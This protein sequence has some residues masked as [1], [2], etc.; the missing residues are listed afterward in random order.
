MAHLH[1][2]SGQVAAP[3][4]TLSGGCCARLPTIEGWP[5]TA[6]AR[7]TTTMLASCIPDDARVALI[8]HDSPTDN[9]GR[10]GQRPDAKQQGKEKAEA[11]QEHQESR[12]GSGSVA[13]R[14]HAQPVRQEVL[15]IARCPTS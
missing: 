13:V 15:V 12:R 3:L 5:A 8:A 11:G 1:W 14:Q 7:G 4:A 2:K 10:H 9:G 6:T